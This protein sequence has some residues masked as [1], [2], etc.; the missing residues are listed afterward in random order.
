VVRISLTVRVYSLHHRREVPF[1]SDRTAG[2]RSKRA[3]T[4]RNIEKRV[5]HSAVLTPWIAARSATN[6]LTFFVASEVVD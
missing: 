6:N 4:C 3:M 2:C 1:A 5:A